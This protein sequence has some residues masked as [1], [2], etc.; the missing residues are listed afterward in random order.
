MFVLKLKFTPP[1]LGT[2]AGRRDVAATPTGRACSSS[3][4]SALP[5][6]AFQAAV[7][8][9]SYLEGRGL[10]LAPDP[11]TKTKTTLEFFTGELNAS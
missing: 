7:E 5:A 11:Q 3:R 6:E 9:R 2:P 1:E 10:D 8:A 4:R